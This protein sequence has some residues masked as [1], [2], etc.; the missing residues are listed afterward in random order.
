MSPSGD[1]C[2]ECNEVNF[3]TA[4]RID[5]ELPCDDYGN[6]REYPTNVFPTNDEMTSPH[7]NQK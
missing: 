4:Y 5:A 2:P 3:P 6:L 1:T 7:R